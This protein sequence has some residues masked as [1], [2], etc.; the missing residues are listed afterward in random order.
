MET[1]ASLVRHA[2][3]IARWKQFLAL[4]IEGFIVQRGFDKG[5][6]ILSIILTLLGAYGAILSSKYYERFRLHVCRV[7]R[8][9]ERL[10]EL[11]PDANLSAIE[12]IADKR[13]MSRHPMFFKIRLHILWLLLYIG[14]VGVGI[15]N[16]IIIALHWSNK[17]G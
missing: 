8:L 2:Y 4:A 17:S 11:H 6:L 14:I 13:H 5:S 12:E 16:I 7:G 15:I 9:M 1:S 10:E 3:P